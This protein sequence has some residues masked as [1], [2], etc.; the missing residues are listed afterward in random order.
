MMPEIRNCEHWIFVGLEFPSGFSA[1]L[2]SRQNGNA[3]SAAH[4][5]AAIS[6]ELWRAARGTSPRLGCS[7]QWNYTV[8]ASIVWFYGNQPDSVRRSRLFFGFFKVSA[9]Y[10]QEANAVSAAFFWGV[11]ATSHGP[12][13]VSIARRQFQIEECPNSAADC[14]RRRPSECRSRIRRYLP[15]SRIA[16]A[17][18][19][20]VWNRVADALFLI[21][22]N[23]VADAF[24]RMV[25]Y[26]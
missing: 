16:D 17:L 12:F 9:K 24:F 6:A 14:P 22:W 11:A 1:S 2:T 23:I 26:Q 25:W 18:F 5:L 15:A 21:V 8:I 20:I 13:R 7:R 19:L 10:R 4:C 3:T